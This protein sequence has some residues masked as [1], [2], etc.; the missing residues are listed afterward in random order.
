[1]NLQSTKKSLIFTQIASEEKKAQQIEAKKATSE[2]NFTNILCA[3]FTRADPKSAKRHSS[4][5]YLFVLLGSWHV[6]AYHKTLVK[7]TPVSLSN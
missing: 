6:K 3:A 2:V 4:H 1:M 7:L 5:Q